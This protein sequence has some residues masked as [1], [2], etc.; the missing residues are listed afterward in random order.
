M[1]LTC[2][3]KV[4]TGGVYDVEN[5]LFQYLS[6]FVLVNCLTECYACADKNSIYCKIVVIYSLHK[7]RCFFF[8][9]IANAFL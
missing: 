6:F 5:V 9:S 7:N 8:W 2:S 4:Q 1:C 3:E